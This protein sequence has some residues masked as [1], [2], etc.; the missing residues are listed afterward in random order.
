MSFAR[1]NANKSKM[2]RRWYWNIIIAVLFPAALCIACQPAPEAEPVVNK[3]DGLYEREL[4]RAQAAQQQAAPTPPPY[5]ACE[6]WSEVLT[7]PNFMVTIDADVELPEM[8]AFPVYRIQPASFL[9]RA[10]KVERILQTLMPE[11][12]GMRENVM[13]REMCE[14]KIQWLGLGAYDDNTGTY[15]PY[16]AE[17]RAE[18]DAEVQQLLMQLASAPDA[19]AFEPLE[20]IAVAGPMDRVFRTSEGEQ[21]TVT[22]TE[23]ALRASRPGNRAYPE[24]WFLSDRGYE[25]RPA[26]T[27][28]QNIRITEDEA[29]ETAQSFLA[30]IGEENWVITSLERA[31][32]LKAYYNVVTDDPLEAEG[33]LVSCIRSAPGAIPFDYHDGTLG[34]M[35][36]DDAAYSAPLPPE[37][38]E[39]FV[40]ESGVYALWWENPVEVTQTVVENIALLPFEQVQGNF[41]QMLKNGLR[42]SDERPATNGE[43]NPTRR[44]IVERILLSYACVQERDAPGSYLLTPA[45]F[46][47]YTTEVEKQ[48]ELQGFSTTPTIFAMNAVDGSRIALFWETALP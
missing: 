14:E 18:V 40:D 10:E 16:S 9:S 43:L 6:H 47:L 34:R 1:K 44:G 42:W 3:G 13:T 24:S 26:P 37:R 28:Y 32:M 33:Y 2:A 15:R 19:N 27:P 21:W 5:T 7:L 12:N 4:E 17:E 35:K 48:G 23:R 8:Q 45:W 30:A 20:A 39:L 11:V 25:G 41:L 38:L 36:F 29:R 22:L 46:F 31:G